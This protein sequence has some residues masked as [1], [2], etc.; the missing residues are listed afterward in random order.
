MF[1]FA[2]GALLLFSRVCSD[3]LCLSV[4]VKQKQECRARWKV[5]SVSHVQT[6]R[7]RV[8]GPLEA[9]LGPLQGCAGGSYGPPDQK[10]TFALFTTVTSFL[11][12][13][14]GFGETCCCWHTCGV[15]EGQMTLILFRFTCFGVVAVVAAEQS[16]SCCKNGGTCILGSF[17]ACPPF[18][19]GRNCEYDQ[20][21]R[22]EHAQVIS[23]CF[24]PACVAQQ[25][26][27]FFLSAGAVAWFLMGSGFRKAA[28]TVAVVT[29]FFTASP[30]S[31]TKTAVRDAN[32][33]Y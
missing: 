14:C 4:D 26:L 2:F 31:F 27:C 8:R 25:Y 9:A 15:C 23:P 28:P 3:S 21:V 11:G 20:R 24:G 10:E 16:R 33:T 7:E 19:T 5:W 12:I 22:W 32:I 30:T 6:D 13:C 29:A 17:C 1:C 18:F